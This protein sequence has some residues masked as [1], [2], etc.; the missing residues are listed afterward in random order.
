MPDDQNP[1][2]QSSI[3]SV[4]QLSQNAKQPNQTEG[5]NL[6]LNPPLVN[7]NSQTTD[8]KPSVLK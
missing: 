8:Q 4:K 3:D 6:N 1:T 2:G 7:N 5:L